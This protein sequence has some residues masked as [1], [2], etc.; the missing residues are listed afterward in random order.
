M[1]DK[2]DAEF[3]VDFR[4]PPDIQIRRADVIAVGVAD[5]NG[6]RI[7]SGFTGEPFCHVRFGE[8]LRISDVGEI[9]GAADVA[10]F[11]LHARSI[12]FRHRN[13]FPRP[14]EVFLKRQAR[15]RHT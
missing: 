13:D 14:G 3:P 11:S 5:G 6:E 1:K 7:D 10:K 9:P 12:F 15:P 8:M 4:Q 2:R